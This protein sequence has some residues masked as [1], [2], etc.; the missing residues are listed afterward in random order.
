MR[1]ELE[2]KINQSIRLLKSIPTDKGDI[3]LS[4]SG[5]KD[6]DVILQ[7]C[8]EAGLKVRVIY[9][10][11]TIDPPGT[12]KHCKEVGAEIV[13]P[14]MS[15]F[16]LVKKK[17]YPS[18]YMRFCC[19]NLKEYKICDIAIQGI[20][21]SESRKRNERYKEPEMCRNYKGKKGE[22]RIYLPIL[23]WTDE[24][25]AEYIEDRNI[26]CAPV[27][28]DE[29]GKFHVERRLGCMCCPLAS[30]K[31]R[32][33]EFHKYPKIVR[34]YIVSAKEFF[35]TKSKGKFDNPID[36]FVATSKFN[37][38]NEFCQVTYTMF[39]K[40]DWR[41]WLEKEF[42]INL[43]DV[44]YDMTNKFNQLCIWE[45]KKTI[46]TCGCGTS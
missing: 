5:G 23:E 22:A 26:K 1:K 6:S 35:G 33:D 36:A 8:K 34:R 31:K 27:Y 21:R 9:K 25:V 37:S 29:E 16:D 2:K 28:Y 30:H 12:I 43:Q 41:S 7:L 46:K 38:Y 14:K 4:Y 24:D 42:G 3:E 20:R 11:T 32:M 39:G 18:R 17:G 19:S 10:N 15:F 44:P 13:R 40:F 45:K